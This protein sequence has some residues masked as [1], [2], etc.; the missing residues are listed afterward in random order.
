V[1]LAIEPGAIYVFDKGYCNYT[2]W[3]DIHQSGATFVTR[4]KKNA[5]L[6]L[7]QERPLG[8]EGEDGILK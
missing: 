8:E 1:R 7:V 2:W 3:H 5:R 6:S 4:F